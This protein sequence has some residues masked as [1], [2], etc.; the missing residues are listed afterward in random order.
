MTTIASADQQASSPHRFVMFVALGL[1]PCLGALVGVSGGFDWASMAA[2]LAV[3]TSVIGFGAWANLYLAKVAGNATEQAR[4]GAEEES[5]R[6]LLGQFAQG[7][8]LKL[9]V[10]PLW[11]LHLETARVQTEEAG[12]SL[13]ARFSGIND[14]LSS[15]DAASSQA[16]AGMGEG[17]GGLP[18]LIQ[19]AEQELSGIVSSLQAAL[20]SKDHMLSQMRELTQYT[21]DL[22]RMARDVGEIASQTNLLALNA[23]IEAARAG[24]AGRGFSVVADEVRKLSNLSGETGKRISEKTQVI[25]T[26]MDA[27]LKLAAQYACHDD[28]VVNESEATIRHV[29]ER[30]QGAVQKL[31]EAAHIL[32]DQSRGVRDEVAEVMVNLQYQDRVNQILAHV[33]ADMERFVAMLQQQ[34]AEIESGRL[35]KPVAVDDWLRDME[36]SYTTLEQRHNHLGSQSGRPE[37]SEITFF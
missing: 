23:A 12:T 32:R 13:A 1:G 21:G 28:N 25:A 29:V 35:P 15:A 34:H 30:F 8:D 3:A 11:S 37:N 9:R 18:A 6:G 33:K 5:R 31:G 22:E 7:E 36:S 14:K 24:E 19:E 2:G 27:T 26:A 4:A 17:S 10:L 20:R 16:A